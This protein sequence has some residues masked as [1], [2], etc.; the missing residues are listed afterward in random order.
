MVDISIIVPVYN[1][2]TYLAEC[3]DS[4]IASSIFDKCELLLIDDGSTDNSY[5]LCQEYQ[6]LYSNI[7]SYSFQN[8]GLS[9]ARNRGVHLAKGKYIFFLDSDDAIMPDYLEILYHEIKDKCCDMVVAGFSRFEDKNETASHV[10]R[11]VLE[12]NQVLTG[13]RYLEKRMDND[14]WDNQVWCALYSRAFLEKNRLDFCEEV[15]LY[16]D[17]LFSNEI[18]LFAE[19]V[20]MIPA[21][22]YLYRIRSQSLSQGVVNERD[23]E[24]TLQVLEIIL[25]KYTHYTVEQKHAIG[26]VLFQVVSMALYYIGEVKDCP[27]TQYYK[28]LS[29]LHLWIPLLKSTAT[30]KEM[31]K[32]ILFRIHW[33]LYYPLVKK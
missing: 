17:I 2:E 12:C 31:M 23:I 27:K 14:D 21:Y 9:A 32:L 16:E 24:C 5:V 30:W 15:R 26:R 29:K 25:K 18:L 6:K 20:Y 22:G 1:V 8:A 3:V 33:G 7:A 11:K 28:R 13:C 4:V 19:K 10:F